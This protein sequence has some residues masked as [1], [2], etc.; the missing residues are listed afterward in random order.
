MKPQQK[1]LSFPFEVVKKYFPEEVKFGLM[2]ILQSG[3]N[4]E[5]WVVNTA[6]CS[7]N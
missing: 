7:Q 1:E 3:S 5:G 4:E 2:L 6:E